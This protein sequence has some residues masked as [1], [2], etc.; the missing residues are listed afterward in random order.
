MFGLGTK[1]MLA[2]ILALGLSTGGLYLKARWEAHRYEAQIKELQEEAVKARVREEVLHSE[3]DHLKKVQV[4]R[5][6]LKHVQKQ[7][8]EVV[9]GDDSGRVV[10]LFNPYRV[11]PQGNPGDAQDGKGGRPGPATGTAPQA[12]SE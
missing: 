1:I 5:K 9:V 11:R 3:I 12:E 6:R 7:I 8:D 10:E 4:A 2:V